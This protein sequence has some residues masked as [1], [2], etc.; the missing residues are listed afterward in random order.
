MTRKVLRLVAVLAAVWTI[1][2]AD[3]PV[4]FVIG[5]LGDVGCC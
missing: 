2:G 5:L 1:A 3:W 4:D